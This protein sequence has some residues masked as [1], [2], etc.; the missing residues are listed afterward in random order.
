MIIPIILIIIAI[1]FS[2]LAAVRPFKIGK[3]PV[4][5]ATG[6]LLALL[7]LLALR[8]LDLETIR[9]GILGNGQ[10]EPWKIIV[11]FFSVAY[12]SI[13]T[14]VTGI[15]DFLAYK[16]TH[17]SNRNGYRLFLFIY[18]FTCVIT[19]FTSNDIDILTL[20]PII[21]YLSKH[22]KIN[23]I[24]LLFAQFFA[25]NIVSMFFYTGNPT[26]IIVA[27]ALGLG[28]LEYTKVMWLP[29]VIA[30]VVNFALLFLFFRKTIT[31][32]YVFKNN[33]N[34]KVRNWF[35]A[36]LSSILLVSMLVVLGFSEYFHLPIWVI[37]VTFAAIFMI[38]DI[39]FGIFY[40]IKESKLSL[41]QLQKGK[42]VYGIPAE[43][44]EFW[45]AFKRVPWKI[46]PFIATFFIFVQGLKQYGV[47][48]YFATIISHFSTSLASGI[49][50]NGFFGLIM[51]NIINNQPMT[52]FL[53][54]ILVSDSFVVSEVV[55]KGSAYAVVVAS[56]LAA[57]VTLI[58]ALAG[59]MWKNILAK[60][61][62]KISYLDFLKK[63]VMITPVVFVVT[64][65]VL[66]L[67]L[68]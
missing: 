3:I 38:E 57:S 61:G 48:D 34:Y 41:V 40:K 60:K 36:V 4:N 19:V 29:T 44:N 63:G 52:I 14:D 50:I 13:S 26:N 33:S 35:D 5:L 15:F 55:F 67:V 16:I 59:L 30:L 23:V 54:N 2:V 68:V 7:I 10:L 66:Y 25:T 51:A 11:I 62:L 46:L 27:N 22:A 32:K 45:V 20:T 65:A 43:K 58:G 56:N 37:T 28:F 47:V 64:L 9:L 53:S 12:V 1:L 17:K 39:I 18:L 8:V 42:D 21:F 24:P 49:A 6:S 31:R